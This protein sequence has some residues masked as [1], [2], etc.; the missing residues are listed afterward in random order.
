MDWTIL[1]IAPTDDKKA[2]T[3][4][5]RAKL[6]TTN[7]ED[8]PEE[9]K[10]LRAA[11]EEALRLADQVKEEPEQDLTPV[12]RWAARVEALYN[13]YPSRINAEKWKELLADDVCAGLDTRPQAEEALL[14]FLMEHYYL[15]RTVWQTL[16]AAFGWLERAEELCEDWPQDFIERCVLNGIRFRQSLSFDQFEPGRDGSVCDAYRRLY[17]QCAHTPPEQRAEL[18]DRLEAM[19]EQ[20]AHGRAMRCQWLMTVGRE[21]E[22]RSGY[23]ELT[24]RWPEDV[25]MNIDYAI[26]LTQSG[27]PDEA[28]PIIRRMLELVPDNIYAQRALAECQ[29]AKGQLSDAKETLYE[30]MHISGDD[31]ILMEQLSA[32]LREWNDTLI[33]Q[34]QEAL[35]KD[36]TDAD[37]AID[38]GWCYL[39]NDQPDAAMEVALKID[40]EKADPFDYHNLLG[41][42]YLHIEMFAEAGEH[43]AQVVSIVRG[44][45]P[46]G[47]DTTEKRI[48]RLPEMLQV[49]GSCLMQTGHSDRARE[50]YQE[51]LTLAPDD[52]KVLS[53]MGN[54]Y[55]ADGRYEQSLEV[56]RHLT[57]V[58]PGSWFGHLMQAL[59]LYKLRRDREAFDAVGR[60]QSLQ[61]GDL[62]L[63]VLKMQILLRNG[64]FD[65]V[66]D[67][68]AFLKEAGAPEDLSTDFI[69]AQLLELAD[70]D[71]DAAFRSYQSIA[72]Q[73]EE[74]ETLLDASALYHRMACIMGNKM[75]ASKP[76]DC[77]ILLSVLEK[78]LSHDK[79]DGDCLNYK[80]W[81]LVRSGKMADAIEMYKTLPIPNAKRKL[82]YTYHD[83]LD[84]YCAEALACCLELLEES[85]T[86]ELYYYA[87]SCCRHTG[88]WDHVERYSRLALELDP[89]DIDAWNALAYLYERSGDLEEALV[90][91]DRALDSMWQL[92]LFYEWLVNHKLKL[93]RRRGR[94]A[95]AL[96][97]VDE[98]MARAD[99]PDGF[100]TKFDICAQFGLWDQAQAVLDQWQSARKGDPEQVKATGQLHLLRG[101]MLKATLA[102]AKVK[103]DMTPD[104]ET[105]LRIQLAD[106]EANAKRQIQLWSQRLDT[107]HGK[108]HVLLNLAL[109]VFWSGDREGAKKIALKG[110]E[111]LDEKLKGYQRDEALYRARRS[112]LL[113]L[114]GREAEARAEL[115]TVRALP[116]CEHCTYGRC[117]DA[118]IFE[119]YIEEI[120]GNWDRARE[121]F[122]AGKQN[123]PDELDFHA[124]ETRLKKKKG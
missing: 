51:A 33:G 93:L 63:Y 117:K 26:L 83:D 101:K 23:R 71:E 104:E 78:G 38:L 111:L 107:G 96:K 29:A 112:A 9:F 21:E 82:L 74:G 75:D 22:C 106:L 84:H 25:T 70:K 3:A 72:R 27:S 64:A 118:D 61:G 10:A 105:S 80:A 66:R 45:T 39:Q 57:E 124:G 30:V 17:Y 15:P 114:V 8:K 18:L 69:R 73:V 1:G 6:K 89:G 32:R 90:C 7:P 49:W 11:Y 121:L 59:C 43:I 100:Q 98:T 13:D 86:P 41:K 115:E 20:H 37:K 54:I 123:W 92:E 53:L 56:L 62:S 79:F 108:S 47:T 97:L 113:A 52:P 60:A 35:Q 65:E 16:D 122:Q 44:L 46:D 34:Y 76:E 102:F 77:E 94:H 103:H 19:P 95:E 81:L 24:A 4:A 28:E 2:I 87:A 42:L 5:Y 120:A 91:I 99:Y 36:P 14:R 55:Y 88:D 119:A 50:V 116:L 67:I 85:P 110:L 40:P 31:P 12:G 58:S 48:R 68:L 109:A